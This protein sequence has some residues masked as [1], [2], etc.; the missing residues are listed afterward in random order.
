MESVGVQ[1]F[2]FFQG[3]SPSFFKHMELAVFLA[4]PVEHEQGFFVFGQ[5]L[6]GILAQLQRLDVRGLEIE[7]FLFRQPFLYGVVFWEVVFDGWDKFSFG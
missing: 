3:H 5:V 7:A 4:E 6:L 1:G 2:E